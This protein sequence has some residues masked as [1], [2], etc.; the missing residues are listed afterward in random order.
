MA[1]LM[2]N[3]TAHPLFKK[4]I[5]NSTLLL[6]EPVFALTSN[7]KLPLINETEEVAYDTKGHMIRDLQTGQYNVIF[8]IFII[9]TTCRL[10]DPTLFKLTYF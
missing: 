3:A 10:M 9:C 8:V 1:S 2:L 4:L 6:L 5:G 7:T